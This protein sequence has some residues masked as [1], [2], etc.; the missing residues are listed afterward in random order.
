MPRQAGFSFFI[1][2]DASRGLHLLHVPLVLSDCTYWCMG[3]ALS[4]PA[5]RGNE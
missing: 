3:A 2:T 1:P 4:L 5:A